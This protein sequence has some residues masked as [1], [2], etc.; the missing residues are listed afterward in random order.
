MAV[1]LDS[2]NPRLAKHQGAYGHEHFA[3]ALCTQMRD[4]D[5]SLVLDMQIEIL[6]TVKKYRQRALRY[7]L[8]AASQYSALLEAASQLRLLKECAAKA[9]ARKRLGLG[10]SSSSCF[11][12]AGFGVYA[13]K[14]NKFITLCVFCSCDIVIFSYSGVVPISVYPCL[15]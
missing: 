8:E 6:N 14:V 2:L 5:P 7:L 3:L 10:V 12:Q 11:E 1:E 9:G 4:V 15:V 13:A